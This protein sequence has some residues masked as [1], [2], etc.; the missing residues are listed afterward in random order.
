M[1]EQQEQ[2]AI[3]GDDG[4]ASECGWAQVHCADP[5]TGEYLGPQDVWVTVGT[6]LPAGAYLDKPI[7]SKNGFVVIRDKNEWVYARDYRGRTVYNTDTQQPQV[8]DKIGS[9]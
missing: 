4:W 3:W 5:V 6:G 9:L 2:Q 1:T 8:I 7:A